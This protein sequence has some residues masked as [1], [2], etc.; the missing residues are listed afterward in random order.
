MWK[1]PARLAAGVLL[2]AALA[3]P[4]AAE[5]A[6]AR[7]DRLGRE[8]LDHWLSRR[9][10]AATRLGLHDRDDRLLPVTQASI[11]EETAWFR[12]FRTRLRA[13][14]R[15]ELPFEPS[16][17]YDVLSARVDRELLD[18]E[19]I[20][21]YQTNPNLYVD[22]IASSVQSLLQ[23]EF[24]PP[25]TRA[26]AAARRLKQVPEVLRA[27]RINLQHPPRISTEVAITQLGGALQFY[28][29]A[30]PA[31]TAG[32]RDPQIQAELAE[33]DSGAIRAAEAFLA[34]LKE[35]LLPRSDG[36]FALGAETYQKKLACD[37]ME[38]APVDS[39]LARGWRA[40]DETHARMEALAAVIAP[41]AG[42][43][44][45]LDSLARDHPDEAH[46]LPAV[47][48]QLDTIRAFLREKKLL[49]LPRREHLIVRET[50]PFRR[51]LSFASMDPPGVWETRAA[52]AYYNVT[53]VDPDWTPRQ[54]SDHLGFFNRYAAEIVSI[55][56]A[57]PGHYYQFLALREAPSRL[58]QVLTSGS[59][60]EGWAHYCEQMAIEQ[61]FG[62]GDPRYE[63]AQLAL[64]IQRIGRLIVGISMHTRDMSYDEAERL[65]EDR[66]YLSPVNAAREARRGALD[67][68][69][70][71]Y[72][73]GKWRILELRD[74]VRARLGASFRLRDFHDAFLRQ[75]GAPLPVVRAGVL[76]ALILDRTRP[77]H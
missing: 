32:C 25:C 3:A 21:P 72:T 51:S 61:G 13:L 20:R 45:A 12:D 22:L 33:A 52:E 28:R 66:C 23:R 55:H 9:P 50:P 38:D 8:F 71:V 74:E 40:L 63:L 41:G 36:R 24:A 47:E 2:A 65:F 18:L 17:D 67:P 53:P 39:L 70:L 57:L 48:S 37:E 15:A 11:A 58:R 30:V 44:A 75:G 27:A 43:A 7:F 76:H 68:T 4:A 6:R 69:Y 10:Q 60:T 42:V 31:L 59:N 77:G 46:L 73:L 26:R 19:V 34:Y 56:E 49:T 62:G 29:E 14:P 64:A 16:L 1:F 35:D 5:T 54:K